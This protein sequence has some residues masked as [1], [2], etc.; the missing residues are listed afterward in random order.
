MSDAIAALIGVGLMLAYLLMIAVK[1]DEAPVW[2]AFGIGIAL[3][4]WATLADSIL[5][6][7]RRSNSN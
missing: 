2:I 3:M 5:P 4:L 6:V 1:L 7:F